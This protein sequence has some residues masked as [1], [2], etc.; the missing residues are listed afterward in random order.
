MDRKDETV[1]MSP[2]AVEQR[3][4]DLSD[5]YE[6]GMALRNA[7]YLGTVEEVRRQEQDVA[8]PHRVESEL[9]NNRQT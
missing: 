9:R 1:D 4:R 3:L 8:G 6:L 5:L 7:R 2:E